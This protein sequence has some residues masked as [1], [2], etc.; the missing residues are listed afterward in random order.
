M[1]TLLLSRM[2][3]HEYSSGYVVVA[4]PEGTLSDKNILK[5]P[6]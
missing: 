4:L 5:I 3:L 2:H 1:R 6:L